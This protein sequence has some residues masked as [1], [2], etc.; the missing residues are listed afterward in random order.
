MAVSKGL[1]M[2]ITCTSN[3]I[4]AEMA[5]VCDRVCSEIGDETEITWGTIIDENLGDEVWVT[6][7]I[8]SGIEKSETVANDDAIYFVNDD[9]K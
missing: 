5:E 8:A 7:I 2:N 3:L 6:I 1:L 9:K 4:M